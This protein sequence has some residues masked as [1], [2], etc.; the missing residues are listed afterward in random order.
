[1]SRSLYIYPN[2]GIARADA[3]V[4]AFVDYYLSDAGLVDA[5]EEADYV[6]LPADRQEATRS[7]WEAAV[8]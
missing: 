8:S 2:V 3:T 7:A 1:M 6:T 5:V 4:K